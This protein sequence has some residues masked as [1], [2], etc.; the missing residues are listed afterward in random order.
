VVKDYSSN[1]E[2]DSSN[3]EYRLFF[4]MFIVSFIADQEKY[5][6]LKEQY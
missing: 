5:A 6:Y 3:N 1:R 4:E 2:S